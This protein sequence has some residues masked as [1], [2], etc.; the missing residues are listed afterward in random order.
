[1]AEEAAEV[2]AEDAA[3]GV[4]LPNK[5]GADDWCASARLSAALR[6]AALC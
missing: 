5:G 1:M 6:L 4:A 2:K 3:R